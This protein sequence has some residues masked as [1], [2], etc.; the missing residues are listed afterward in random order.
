M[1]KFKIINLFD[2][3]FVSVAVFLIIY[4]WTNFYIRNLWSTFIL[5]LIFS[6]AIVYLIFH[7]INSKTNKIISNKKTT[8][9]IEKNFL[10]F[11]L[12]SKEKKICLIESILKHEY[13]TS[14]DSNN[15]FYKKE[16][17]LHQIIFATHIK[18]LS[19]E[20]LINLIDEFQINNACEFDII[21]NE[22]EFNIKKQLFQNKNINFISKSM[23][24]YDFFEKFKIFPD[25]S[26]INLSVTK[27]SFKDLIKNFFLPKKAKSY[28]FCGLILIFSSLILPYHT[29]YIF[30][31]TILMIMSI[32]CKLIPNIRSK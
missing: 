24:F 5:S 15:L 30:T 6:F 28:F 16:N 27:F 10:C 20:D 2:K 32:V 31:G 12:L 19:N 26:N 25:S 17:K 4:A 7:L 29:Y 1:S 13:E 21:C 23:L 9:E 18:K 14:V 11:R 8:E 22:V 3:V